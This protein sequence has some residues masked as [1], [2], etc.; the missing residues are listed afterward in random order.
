MTRQKISTPDNSKRTFYNF[1]NTE[2]IMGS[3]SH[4]IFFNLRSRNISYFKSSHAFY[5]NQLQNT[6]KL[7]TIILTIIII[8]W[9]SASLIKGQRLN[10][11]R[12]RDVTQLPEIVTN[13]SEM[14]V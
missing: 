11:S 14:Y 10:V 3:G 12:V 5:K 2:Y 7:K 1:T 8:F 4:K 9:V 6:D 13:L